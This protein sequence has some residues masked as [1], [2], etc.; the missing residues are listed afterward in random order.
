MVKLLKTNFSES[1]RP[2]SSENQWIQ[3]FWG[4][5]LVNGKMM[6]TRGISLWRSIHPVD[7]HEAHEATFRSHLVFKL[8]SILSWFFPICGKAK[9]VFMPMSLVFNPPIGST[10]GSKQWEWWHLQHKISPS[11]FFAIAASF[12]D[13]RIDNSLQFIKI[14]H[15]ILSQSY[16]KKGAPWCSNSPLNY[17]NLVVH[18]NEIHASLKTPVISAGS[19]ISSESPSRGSTLS[20]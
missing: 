15:P 16:R 6:Q 2:I 13:H 10:K 3:R 1:P 7:Q 9:P 4:K 14:N 8:L 11:A 19:T 17:G 5:K 12:D 18:P 20:P